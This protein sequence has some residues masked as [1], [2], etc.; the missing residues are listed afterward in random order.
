MVAVPHAGPRAAVQ[1]P[2]RQRLAARKPPYRA[3]EGMKWDKI[4][5]SVWTSG[6]AT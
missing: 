6:P 2:E 5:S 3:I 4:A 1:N